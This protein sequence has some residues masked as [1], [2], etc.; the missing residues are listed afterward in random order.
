MVLGVF[1]FCYILLKNIFC[2]DSEERFRCICCRRE[3][4]PAVITQSKAITT[5]TEHACHATDALSRKMEKK[6]KKKEK[7][8]VNFCM[9]K[10]KRRKKNA[11]SSFPTLEATGG[12]L[13][14]TLDFIASICGWK[15]C[16]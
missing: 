13:N 4:S 7:V 2:F 9:E 6:K 14:A 3:K 15:C 5:F 12:N 10:K 8:S 16:C 11:R 1:C